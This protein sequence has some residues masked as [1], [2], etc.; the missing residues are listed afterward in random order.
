MKAREGEEIV[1]ECSGQPG[2]F[3]LTLTKGRV[4]R[5]G[6]CNFLAR[7]SRRSR[8]LGLS[9]VR[10]GSCS[11]LRCRSVARQD[12]TRLAV[13]RKLALTAIDGLLSAR[14]GPLFSA[15]LRAALGR[16]SGFTSAA[17]SA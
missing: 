16:L 17:K 5:R 14:R 10:R 2:P 15:R 12:K 1:Y 7:R 3:C 13:L 9:E 4:S 8:L 11:A 6:H